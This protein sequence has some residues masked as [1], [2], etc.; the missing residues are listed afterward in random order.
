MRTTRNACALAAAAMVWAGTAAAGT[1]YLPLAIN[2]PLAGKSYR[3]FVSVTNGSGAPQEVSVRYIPQDTVGLVANPSIT[4]SKLHVGPGQTF[5]LAVGQTGVGMVELSGSDDVVYSGRLESL[6]PGGIVRSS[7]HLPVIGSEDVVP[8]G[9]VV[10]IQWG[11]RAPA[12][13]ASHFGL[14]TFG[15]RDG[16]CTV[17]TFRADGTQVLSTVTLW[18]PAFGQRWFP[19]AFGILQEPSIRD[20]RFEVRCDVPSFPFTTIFGDAPDST[21]FVVPSA[22]GAADLRPPAPAPPGQLVRLPGRFFTAAKGASIHDVEVPIPPGVRYGRLVYEFDVFL[23]RLIDSGPGGNNAN[24]H[25]TTLLLRPVKGGTHLAHTI[26]GNEKYKSVLDL[27]V[28]K[29]GIVRGSDGAWKPNALHHVRIDY[30]VDAGRMT[31]ELSRNGVL[32]ERLVARNG[33]R[34]L[35]HR[36]E[37]LHILFGLDR[38]YDEGGYL[39]PYKAEFSNLVVTGRPPA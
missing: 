31:W 35:T 20:A 25:S 38:V 2:G 33:V 24:F 19:D 12:G 3:T 26:R 16:E 8:A 34:E 1:V 32:I 5:K 15:S 10:H 28:E 11:E 23:P 22:S 6:T 7:A 21:Q 18:G 14:T 17:N 9:E 29:D 13:T 39:P 30:D 36:G 4:T 37:G 27:G